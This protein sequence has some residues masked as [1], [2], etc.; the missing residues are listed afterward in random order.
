MFTAKATVALADGP[1]LDMLLATIGP[2]TN[3]I[4]IGTTDDIFKPEQWSSMSSSIPRKPAKKTTSGPIKPRQ[5]RAIFFSLG[6]NSGSKL[7]SSILPA[8]HMSS[9]TLL[10]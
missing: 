9:S 3:F 8:K 6:Y 5:L 10:K 1:D 4:T 7:S 2:V